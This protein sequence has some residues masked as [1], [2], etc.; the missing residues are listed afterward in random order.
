MIRSKYHVTV[1]LKIHKNK[2][3][4]KVNKWNNDN[5][6]MYWCKEAEKKTWKLHTFESY[7]CQDGVLTITRKTRIMQYSRGNCENS[8]DKNGHGR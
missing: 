6:I 7:Q 5:Y 8:G 2:T 4:G 3:E 1:T